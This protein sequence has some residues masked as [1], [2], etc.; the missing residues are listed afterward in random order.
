M[1]WSTT[2]FWDKPN[3]TYYKNLENVKTDLVQKRIQNLD[4]KPKVFKKDVN[5]DFCLVQNVQNP[6]M[7]EAD[8]N[9]FMH[10][11][12][13]LVFAAGKIGGQENLYRVLKTALC[14]DLVEQT[15][16]AHKFV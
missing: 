12:N 13:K 3:C 14:E 6:T 4:L 16:F 15:N 8:C 9:Q 1:T 5:R 7:E 2:A 10:L 11:R